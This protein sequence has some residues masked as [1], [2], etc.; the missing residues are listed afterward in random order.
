[1]TNIERK[2]SKV[3]SD[4]PGGAGL[5][6]RFDKGTLTIKQYHYDLNTIIDYYFNKKEQ[7][8]GVQDDKVYL[9][10][11]SFGGWTAATTACLDERI[12]VAV[13][14]SPILSLAEIYGCMLAEYPVPLMVLG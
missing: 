8:T 2:Y 12:N 11:H 4:F 10:G 14:Q 13:P 5:S 7:E 3:K 9:A 1:M 6:P